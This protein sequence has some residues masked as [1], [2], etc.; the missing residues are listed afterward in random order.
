MPKFN[1]TIRPAEELVAVLKRKGLS[2]ADEAKAVSYIR[3]IGY[4]RLKA[5]FYPLYREPK[6]KHIF[7][8]NATFDKVMNMY[9][10]DR[11]LRLLLFNEIEKIEVA[12]RSVIV[13]IVSEELGDYFWMTERKYFKNESHF[14]SSLN[15]IRY[16][17]EKSKEEFIIHFKNKYSDPFPP[18]WMIVEI[19]PLAIY[20]I[21]L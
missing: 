4:Y 2:I 15:L 19:L 12:F 8:I 16:E 6:H 10:F 1:K 9:R 11:K 3:N 13:N 18:S 21:F 5:Y 14:K 7:K 20:V 17:Y